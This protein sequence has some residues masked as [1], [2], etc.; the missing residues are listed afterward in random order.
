MKNNKI[1]LGLLAMMLVFGMTVVSCSSDDDNDGPTGGNA[2]IPGTADGSLSIANQ[3]VW[4]FNN[5]GNLV[6]Y[7]GTRPAV[8]H[9]GFGGTGSITNGILTFNITPTDVAG[10]SLQP[11]EVIFGWLIYDGGTISVAGVQAGR[12]MSLNA[13]GSRLERASISVQEVSNGYNF[14]FEEVEFFY[15]DRDVIISHPGGRITDEY[16][17]SGF[18]YTYI[19]TISAFRV[20][21]QQGWNALHW[22]QTG[23]FRETSPTTA[24]YNTT[25]TLHVGNP[26]NLR[27][28]ID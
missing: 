9:W 6:H 27:W 3:R 11:L 23:T 24:T 26:A 19:H 16:N 1:W 5:A 7:Y 2:G 18:I 20:Y 22:H 15:V 10:A 12:F 4:E 8:N 21:L 28:F 13:G 17:D 14:T 25:W